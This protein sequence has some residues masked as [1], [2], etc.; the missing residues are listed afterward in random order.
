MLLT[1]VT[2]VI[3]FSSPRPSYQA[4]RAYQGQATAP[5]CTRDRHSSSENWRNEQ[6]GRAVQWRAHWSGVDCTVDLRGVGEA[7]F[8]RD[9]TDVVS[10]A[11]NGSLDIM[12]MNGNETRKITLRANGNDLTRTW[13]VNGHAQA[14]NDDARRWLGEFLI[15]LDRMS[16]IGVDYRLPSI[17]AR[18]GV[19]G[20][21]AETQLMPGDYVKSLYM[22]RMIETQKLSDADYQHVV[23]V[24]SR[25]FTSD[26]EMSRLLRDVAERSP[27]DNDAMRKSYLDAVNKMT[28]DYERSRV[29]QT[30]FAKSAMTHEVAEASV[31]A[32]GTFKSDYERSRVLLAAIDSKALN[33]TD[34]VPILEIAGRSKSDYEKSRVLLAVVG[35]W[36]L[37][38]DGRKAYLSAA[39]GI[40]SDYENR[41]VLAALVK[42]EGKRN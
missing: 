8:N 11:D 19:N 28:S 7:K 24:A 2:V 16:G 27:L 31:R 37:N 12:A 33:E 1:F 34:V 40:K 18:A 20:V 5:I 41:R 38:A 42:Q 9:F 30:I 32:A 22:R 39:D 25:D 29:L 6:D 4:S 17:Y 36:N 3:A 23:A 14:W 35:H 15:E 21:L 10:I 26:Y 13:I